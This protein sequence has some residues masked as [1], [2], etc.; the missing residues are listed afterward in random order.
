[1]GMV[2]IGVLLLCLPLELV[3]RH[4]VYPTLLFI[5]IL[6]MYVIIGCLLHREKVRLS[7]LFYA[8]VFPYYLAYQMLA[9]FTKKWKWK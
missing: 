5:G 1:M 8:I 3:V 7:Y 2:I 4:T 9:S 6:E